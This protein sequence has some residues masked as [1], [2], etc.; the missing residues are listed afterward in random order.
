MNILY[1]YLF[2]SH[3]TYSVSL[4]LS[5][6]LAQVYAS[7]YGAYGRLG[8]GGVDSVSTPTLIASLATRGIA[9]THNFFSHAPRTKLFSV[10]VCVCVLKGIV[11]S[12]VAC[13]SGG[14]HCLALTN[15]GEMYS[16]GEGDDGKL[17]HGGTA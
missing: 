15:T 17:G 5:L 16:W 8:I 13:H 14:K 12:K 11:V 4:P 10:C 1:I 9:T 7:G 2:F 6:P 3:A